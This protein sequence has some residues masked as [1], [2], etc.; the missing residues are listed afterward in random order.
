MDAADTTAP[1]PMNTC[2]PIVNGKNAILKLTC[3]CI[4]KIFNIRMECAY[5][6]LNCL[7][8][9]RITAFWL[10]TQYRPVRTFDKSPRMIAPVW[11]ITLPLSTMFCDPHRTVFRLTLFPEAYRIAIEMRKLANEAVSIQC[12]TATYLLRRQINTVS[13]YSSLSYVRGITSILK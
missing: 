12:D 10:I 7:Y 1:S 3:H 9:G 2:S 8:A 6:V 11:T 4:S 13:I 5:P